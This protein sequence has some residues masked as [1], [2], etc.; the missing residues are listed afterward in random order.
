MRGFTVLLVVSLFVI[1]SVL[2]A[3]Q[4]PPIEPGARVRVTAPDCGLEQQAGTLEPSRGDSLVLGTMKCPLSS[5]TRLDMSRG[6][7]RNTVKGVELGLFVGSVTG[8]V[9]GALTYDT[10]SCN[11]Q[12]ICASTVGGGTQRT[13]IGV[14]IG[15]GIGVAAGAI[16]GAL[17]KIERWEEVPLDPLR[18]SFAPQREGQI[19]FRLSVSF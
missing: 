2:S 12:A 7:R 5:V 19:A 18:V 1:P 3:Q 10:E 9:V 11:W 4:Q 15:A 8:G 6:Q 14:G 13:L 17:I 16:V